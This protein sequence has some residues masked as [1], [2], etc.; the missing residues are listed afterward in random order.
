MRRAVG[1][2]TYA[3]RMTQTWTWTL[4]QAVE[5]AP[6]AWWRFL[7]ANS[8]GLTIALIFVGAAV[9]VVLTKWKRDRCLKLL[10]GSHV[11]LLDRD[12]AALWGDLTVLSEGVELTFDATYR[13][14]RG[15]AKTSVLVYPPVMPTL[16]GLCRTEQ[17]LN[18]AERADRRAQVRRSFRP[19]FWRRLARR[20]R[21]L[22]NTFRDAF[23][24]ALGA[25][26]GQLTKLRP[27]AGL[28][29]REG[30]V[31]QI[32]TT[33]LGAA[34][35]AYEPLLERHVGQPVVVSLKNPAAPDDEPLELPGYLVDYNEHHLAVF[36]VQHPTLGA[37]EAEVG[38]GAAS[39]GPNVAVT[40]EA[41][42][43][44]VRNP[45]PEVIRVAEVRRGGTRLC[46]EAVL[47]PGTA[48]RLTVPGSDPVRVSGVTLRRMDLVCPRAIATVRYGGEYAA[49]DGRTQG[50]K[51]AG[52]APG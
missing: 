50:A 4:G 7:I 28:A 11:T 13:D 21:N 22:L 3:E 52:V 23:A 36:N 10:D 51:A 41:A 39:D 5:S 44:T 24:K 9:S 47:L 1:A 26:V 46:P 19:G 48:L 27:G 31:T 29:G 45:G 34:G 38:D 33:L 43:L 35:N 20:T 17:G 8:F 40:L 14:R 12:G 15:V 18:D 49:E 32:G 16:R 37:W 42:A 25:L 30:D 6:Q 2:S